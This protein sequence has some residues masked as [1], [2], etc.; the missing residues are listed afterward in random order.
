[1]LGGGVDGANLAKVNS[2]VCSY[3]LLNVC[4]AT[5][6]CGTRE[7]AP[8]GGV[9]VEQ[10]IRRRILQQVRRLMGNNDTSLWT[11]SVVWVFFCLHLT[12][13]KGDRKCK[14]DVNPSQ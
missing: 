10:R 6:A 9:Y 14:P 13:Y 2:T 11:S 5:K 3:V 7:M 8:E 4:T 12:V 1:M